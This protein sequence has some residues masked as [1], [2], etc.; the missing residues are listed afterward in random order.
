MHKICYNYSAYDIF[1]INFKLEYK[2]LYSQDL[3]SNKTII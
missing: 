1:N 3:L 2:Y